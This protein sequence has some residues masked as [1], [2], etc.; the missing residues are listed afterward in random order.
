A[1]AEADHG[2]AAGFEAIS[3]RATDIGS[4]F[5]MYEFLQKILDA[6]LCARLE[7][8]DRKPEMVPISFVEIDPPDRG[9]CAPQAKRHRVDHLLEPLFA[10]PKLLFG[11]HLIVD[12]VTYAIPLHDPPAFS[13]RFRAA[14]HP[15]IH[16]I[17]ATKPAPHAEV[18][19]ADQAAAQRISE[20][21][22]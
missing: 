1:P 10:P 13:H 11:L 21:H 22:G 15:A 5:G 2:A 9:R 16:A 3:Q 12:V 18:L 4:V 19:P 17:G 6:R 20:L 14:R 8:R 7:A